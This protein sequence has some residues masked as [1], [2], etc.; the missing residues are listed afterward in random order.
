MCD[1]TAKQSIVMVLREKYERIEE[2]GNLTIRNPRETD[3]T[4]P[5]HRIQ[6]QYINAQTQPCSCR[7]YTTGIDRQ[8][9]NKQIHSA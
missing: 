6:A 8:E 2:F 5:D 7:M 3:Q 4:R 9:G 1:S